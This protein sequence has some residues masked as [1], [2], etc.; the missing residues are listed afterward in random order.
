MTRTGVM[1]HDASIFAVSTRLIISA[2]VS[3]LAD[4]MVAVVL[5]HHPE[6]LELQSSESLDVGPLSPSLLIASH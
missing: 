6:K 4:I 2:V 3:G 1:V 5:A